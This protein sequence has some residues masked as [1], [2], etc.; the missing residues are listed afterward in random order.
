M[1]PKENIRCTPEKKLGFDRRSEGRTGFLSGQVFALDGF[2][3][4]SNRIR[5]NLISY[6]RLKSRGRSYRVYSLGR[7]AEFSACPPYRYSGLSALCGTPVIENVGGQEMP[8]NPQW[9]VEIPSDSIAEF[10]CDCKFTFCKSN[11]NFVE[12]ILI[13]HDRP[14]VTQFIRQSD[15]SRLKYEFDS[16]GE[17]FSPTSLDCEP[18]LSE[19]YDGVQFPKIQN[20]FYLNAEND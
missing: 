4:D 15:S 7:R 13:A 14:H 20:P 16:I 12:Y 2:G 18:E 11:E 1:F 3:E 19:L 6:L 8:V 17:R 9:I 10:D 5:K